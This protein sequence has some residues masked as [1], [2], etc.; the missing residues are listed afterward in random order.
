MEDE[1]CK[2]LAGKVS[3]DLVNTK[4][5]ENICRVR[6]YA[7]IH[8]YKDPENWK[9]VDP[10]HYLS[11]IQ[12]HLAMI[13]DGEHHDKETGLLHISHIAC[14]CMFLEWFYREGKL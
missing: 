1:S 10:K 13:D 14:N 3:W 6:E 9:K 4:L 11:A 12:R 2:V 8:K 7:T 5:L